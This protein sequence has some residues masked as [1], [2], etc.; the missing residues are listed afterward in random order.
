MGIFVS[1]VGEDICPKR[2]E[3]LWEGK[4]IFVSEVGKLSS[5]K[6]QK[7]HNPAGSKQSEE[8]LMK[9]KANAKKQMMTSIR[10]PHCCFKTIME[11]ILM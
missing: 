1:Q 5:K 8:I 6:R 11:E 2:G 3:Y 7:P 9:S 10:G 4:K